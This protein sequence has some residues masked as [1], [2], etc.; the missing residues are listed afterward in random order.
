MRL[1]RPYIPLDIRCRTILRQLGELWPDE[2]IR[3]APRLAKLLLDKKIE[4]ANLIGCKELDLRLDHDPPLAARQRNGEGKDTVYTPDANDPEFLFYRPHGTQFEGSHD[5][6]TRIRGDHGQY[7][8]L[9]LIKRERRRALKQK[10]RSAAKSKRKWPN[11]LRR[12]RVKYKWPKR[13]I[14]SRKMQ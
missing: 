9:V 2:V 6:K 8:D 14:P 7:S 3:S 12:S 5:V 13:K 10:R 1:Y 11:R 4:F